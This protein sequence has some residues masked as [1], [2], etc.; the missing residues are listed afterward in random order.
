MSTQF[1]SRSIKAALPRVAGNA[2]VIR[3]L[4][5]SVRT[6][7]QLR[8]HKSHVHVARQCR[9]S[10]MCK[11]AATLEASN[12][13]IIVQGRNVKLTEALKEF[14]VSPYKHL[15]IK[16]SSTKSD[17]RAT[18]LRCDICIIINS[19]FQSRPTTTLVA[20]LPSCRTQKYSCISQVYSLVVGCFG[21]ES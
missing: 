19:V 1:T 14:A 16:C 11:A 6:G 10:L 13:K 12:L 9:Q 18:S 15:C 2:A 7:K 3:L 17:I 8:T 4:P 20:K 21:A 5:C